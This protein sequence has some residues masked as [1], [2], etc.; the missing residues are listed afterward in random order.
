M[1]SGLNMD[2]AL[3]MNHYVSEE[4]QT[5]LEYLELIEDHSKMAQQFKTEGVSPHFECIQFQN[6]D[7][8]ENED[9]EDVG[10]EE[11]DPEI[12]KLRT[13]RDQLVKDYEEEL[14]RM[15]AKLTSAVTAKSDAEREADKFKKA[16]EAAKKAAEAAKRTSST[17]LF[18]TT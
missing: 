5:F 9:E 15:K 8:I 14:K 12:L 2:M 3:Q 4:T 18:S 1:L 6:D 11:E 10:Q 17:P 13:E 7:Q 16:A